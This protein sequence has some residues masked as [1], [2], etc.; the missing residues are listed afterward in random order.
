M[1]IFLLIVIPYLVGGQSFVERDVFST[2]TNCYDIYIFFINS[3]CVEKK[4]KWA[5]PWIDEDGGLK[6]SGVVLM[7]VWEHSES[8]LAVGRMG[9][10]RDLG[11]AWWMW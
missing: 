5:L 2:E 4:A 8:K 1:R 3:N 11:R 7:V 9:R 6:R 10:S